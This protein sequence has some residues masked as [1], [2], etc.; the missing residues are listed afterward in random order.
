[1]VNDPIPYVV[2]SLRS[3]IF[4]FWFFFVSWLV[5]IVKNQSASLVQV[6]WLT[7]YSKNLL[8]FFPLIVS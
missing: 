6:L 5:E 7:S 8:S 3:R 1:M 4:F 2:S